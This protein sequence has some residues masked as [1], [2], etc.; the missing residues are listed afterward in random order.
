LWLLAWSL[1]DH[2]LQQEDARLMVAAIDAHRML[3]P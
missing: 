1:R 2:A 3:N